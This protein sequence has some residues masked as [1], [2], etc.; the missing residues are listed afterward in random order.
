MSA[1]DN[2]D[3]DT[4]FEEAW[5]CI[6]AV[7]GWLS[8]GQE[9]RLFDLVSFL[10]KNA[11]ILE[12]G[13][14]L[15]RS[16]VAM[17]SAIGATG[18]HIYSV[19]TFCGNNSDFINGKNEISWEG[20]SFLNVYEDNL[21]KAGVRDL[22]TPIRSFSHEFADKWCQPLDMVF[23]DAGHEY[24]DVLRDC[25]DY[26]S[27]VKLGGIVALHDVTPGWPGVHRV[28]NEHVAPQLI[29][30]DNSGSLAHGVKR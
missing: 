18:K 13:C 20:D 9:R 7:H 29:N 19:D 14:Y 26:F 28:W 1:P 11:R 21:S 27:H 30:I 17:A 16:T 8:P 23:I 5:P 3:L 10:P 6:D 22:V 12:I 2:T 25:E 24:E 4:A 15:G